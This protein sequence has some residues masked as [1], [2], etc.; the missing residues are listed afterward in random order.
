[1]TEEDVGMSKKRFQSLVADLNDN[2]NAAASKYVDFNKKFM[3]VSSQLRTN[4]ED[5]TLL[6]N[7]VPSPF[8]LI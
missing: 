1:L 5:V 2:E 8:K 3:H 7:N 4:K 6:L